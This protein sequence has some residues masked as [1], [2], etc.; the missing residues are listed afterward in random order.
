MNKAEFYVLADT[1]QN[2]DKNTLSDLKSVVKDFPFFQ[3]AQVLL[4]KNLH[5]LNHYE[6]DAVLKRTAVSIPSRLHLYNIIHNKQIDSN[7]AVIT[8]PTNLDIADITTV[9]PTVDQPLEEYENTILHPTEQENIA[10][11]TTESQPIIEEPTHEPT[12]VVTNE[13]IADEELT[14]KAAVEESN[15]YA[16][17][18]PISQHI[19]PTTLSFTEWLKLSQSGTIIHTNDLNVDEGI[20][21]ETSKE[22]SK[23][24]VS[25]HTSINEVEEEIT[26]SNTK[27][28]KTESNIGQFESIL[29]KFIRENPRMSR[30]KA[31]F[32]N[33]ANMAKQS[34]Q[35]DEEIATETLAK[36][37]MAQGHYKK[38]IRVYEKLC[39]IYPHRITYF[40]DLIQK[41]KNEH[42]EK[43]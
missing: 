20:S 37:Y 25:L 32:Y 21:K 33:P 8:V 31:E 23:D 41:I 13:K 34:V 14:A 24:E 4:L 43:L 7:Q 26:K 19:Q 17:I 39:L 3:A 10:T 22:S 12:A 36:V 6:Y 42:K 40:A 30:P 29:D 38:A 9:I 35:E 28:D 2:L 18:E 16:E 5:N 11:N 1:T 15:G 27:S